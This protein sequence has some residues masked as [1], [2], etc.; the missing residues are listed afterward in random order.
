MDVKTK[1]VLEYANRV[2]MGRD[3]IA[4]KESH[5]ND[6][7]SDE[8]AQTLRMAESIVDHAIRTWQR[9]TAPPA[10]PQTTLVEV[11]GQ[12]DVPEAERE[13]QDLTVTRKSPVL[14]I[15]YDERRE[16]LRAILQ[17]VADAS[18]ARAQADGLALQALGE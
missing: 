9:R 6:S 8:A 18:L 16:W 5:E 3:R 14:P 11:A 7:L 15:T 2:R 12:E 4:A 1:I 13:K 10:V 17:A